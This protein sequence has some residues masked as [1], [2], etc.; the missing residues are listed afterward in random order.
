MKDRH[1]HPIQM[2]RVE[3]TWELHTLTVVEEPEFGGKA[4]ML[5]GCVQE[6]ATSFSISSIYG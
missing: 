2:V 4:L 5:M 1:P 6:V 3:T